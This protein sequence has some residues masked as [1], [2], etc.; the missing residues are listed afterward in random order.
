MQVLEAIIEVRS[1]KYKKVTVFGDQRPFTRRLEEGAR[2][3]MKQSELLTSIPLCGQIFCPESPA[4][5]S[6]P[7][8]SS[9]LVLCS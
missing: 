1:R 7:I 9:W 3:P 4:P 2:V 6:S 8:F 5:S